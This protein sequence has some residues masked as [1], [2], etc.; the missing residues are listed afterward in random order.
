METEAVSSTIGRVSVFT[1][2]TIG[3]L[4]TRAIENVSAESEE[5]GNKE[6]LE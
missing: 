4:G 2:L 1:L 3:D 5:L 6:K